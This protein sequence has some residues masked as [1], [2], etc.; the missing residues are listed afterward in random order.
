MYQKMS[1]QSNPPCLVGIWNFI[2]ESSTLKR[3]TMEIAVASNDHF[4]QENWDVLG[5]AVAIEHHDC[6]EVRTL[7]HLIAGEGG[8]QLHIVD[9]ENITSFPEWIEAVPLDQPTMVYLEPGFWLRNGLSK[10]ENQHNWPECPSH[11]DDKAYVF[12]KDLAHYLE[13]KARIQPIIFVTSVETIHELDPLLRRAGLFDRRINIPELDHEDVALAFIEDTGREWMDDS[14]HKELKRLGCL[15]KKEFSDQRRRSLFQKAIKRLAWRKG[16]KV[17]Y[18]ELVQFAAY[19]TAE[20]D[21]R[22]DPPEIRRRH[23]IH[24]AG[25]ALVAYLDSKEKSLPEYCSVIKRGGTHGLMVKAYES[26]ERISDDL[27]FRDVTHD[28][29]VALAGRAAENLILGPFEASAQGSQSDLNRATKLAESL[30][31]K[32][33]HSSDLTTEASAAANLA[34]RIDTPS[35]SQCAHTEKLIR[36]FLQDQFIFVMKMLK[37]NS[38]ILNK[39]VDALNDRT[40]LVKED[41][42]DLLT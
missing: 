8:M 28:I 6:D 1:E 32:W 24:E 3:W 41:F 4:N 29:R 13:N 26:H 33:G 22:L 11:D 19:G 20:S 7:I 14:V 30:F 2:P 5:H 37:E 27:S 38:L 42:I 12:R 35:N 25:H 36:S 21:D 39:I 16:E 23:A 40:V 31:A 15:V 9:R 34:V 17:S 10:E 18:K